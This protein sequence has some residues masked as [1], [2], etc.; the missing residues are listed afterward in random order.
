MTTRPLRSTGRQHGFDRVVLRRCARSLGPALAVFASLFLAGACG[1]SHSAPTT[2]ASSKPTFCDNYSEFKSEFSSG[3]AD[4]NAAHGAAEA[5][6]Q[7]AIAQ[8]RRALDRM[9]SSFG[10]L[11][12]ANTP[13]EIR[14]A[15][16][17]I[18]ELGPKAGSLT[19][20]DAVNESRAETQLDSFASSSC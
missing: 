20:E 5:D 11:A 2:A 15:V 3:S 7:G 9:K 19:A 12:G 13:N 1:G 4:A 14:S 16:Q 18:V 10:K 6:P 8:E 17:T